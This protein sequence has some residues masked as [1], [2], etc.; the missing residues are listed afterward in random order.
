MATMAT[1]AISQQAPTL[2]HLTLKQAPIQQSQHN[3]KQLKSEEGKLS[4]PF[5]EKHKQAKKQSN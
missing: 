4:S 2:L 5:G 3:Q 1:T